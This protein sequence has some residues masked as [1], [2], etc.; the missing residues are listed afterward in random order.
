MI[1]LQIVET[2]NGGD[3]MM[4]GGDLAQVSGWENMVY[5]ALFGGNVEANTDP[6]RPE[7]TQDFSWWGNALLM[8]NQPGLQFNSNTERVLKSVGLTSGNL[9]AIQNAVNADLAFMNDFAKVSITVS[10]IGVDKVKLDIVV[11]EPGTLNSMQFVY[12]WDGTAQDLAGSP[13]YSAPPAAHSQ[14]GLQYIEQIQL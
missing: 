6:A 7:N 14:F 2:G 4:I 12:I 8:P 9:P 10:I 5:L 3:L 11:K 13:N 1:D